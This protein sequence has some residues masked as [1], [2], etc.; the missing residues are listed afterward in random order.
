M[1]LDLLYDRS[2]RSDG[3][4]YVTYE[5]HHDATKAIREFDGANAKGKLSPSKPFI[6][7]ILTHARPTHPPNLSPLRPHRR[8]QSSKPLRLSRRPRPLPR[9]PHLDPQR[10]QPLRLAHPPLRRQRPTTHQRRPLRPR[11]RQSI[12]QPRP[13][14][15]RRPTTR[16]AERAWR[17]TGRWP[18]W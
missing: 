1:K 12:S 15:T 10:P 9:R 7:N 5:S 14:P 18:W 16:S 6:P 13:A 11:P 4:A 3:V 8:R 2:G 17:E